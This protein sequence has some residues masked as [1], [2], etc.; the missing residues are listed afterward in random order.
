MLS[1]ADFI[2]NATQM[3]PFLVHSSMSVAIFA[4]WRQTRHDAHSHGDNNDRTGKN[5]NGSIHNV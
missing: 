1:Y 2:K 5:W 4:L 3:I